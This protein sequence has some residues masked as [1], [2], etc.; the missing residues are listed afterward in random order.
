MVFNIPSLNQIYL[1][2]FYLNQGLKIVSKADVEFIYLPKILA[3][4]LALCA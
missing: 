4:W 3:I 2:G 1:I